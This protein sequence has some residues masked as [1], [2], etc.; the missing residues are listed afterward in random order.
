MRRGELSAEQAEAISDAASV[1]P[2]AERTLLGDA[3]RKSRRCG[4]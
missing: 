1:N 4:R 2:D 3:Q